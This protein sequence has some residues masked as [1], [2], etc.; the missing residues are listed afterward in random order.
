LVA[1]ARDA[2]PDGGKLALQTAE[3]H[4]DA[5]ALR[6]SKG[7]KP[8][9]YALL[10][11]AD[12]G[13]GMDAETR[14]RLFEPFFSTKS[15]G[16]GTG[17]G[18]AMV[19]AIVEQSGGKIEVYSEPGAGTTVNLFFPISSAAAAETQSPG[20]TELG[21]LRGS[22]AVLVVEDDEVL[23]RMITQ[24]LKRSGYRVFGAQDGEKALRLVSRGDIPDLLLT[25]LVMPGMSGRQLAQGLCQIHPGMKVVFMSGYA[26]D[27]I[28]VQGVMNSQVDFLQKPFAPIRL[29]QKLREVLGVR[30]VS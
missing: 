22:E 21:D 2:M 20:K 8:G 30:A 3:T 5:E 9:P 10:S 12:T 7:L 27:S 16:G 28:A 26:R 4:L 17:L 29:L 11:I 18:M 15:S 19:F 1:N 25:D 13:S 14:S 6:S 23:L 24:I